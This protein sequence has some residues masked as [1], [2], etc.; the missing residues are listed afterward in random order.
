MR[1]RVISFSEKQGYGFITGENGLDYFVHF[2]KIMDESK[3]LD[4]N[5]IVEFEPIKTDKGSEAL[6]V[7]SILTFEMVKKKAEKKKMQL[8]ETLDP[9]KHGWVLV[10]KNNFIK[11]SENGMF[12]DEINKYLED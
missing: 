4:V 8:I 9:P 12:L 2:S 3:H 7:T 10:D 1:G 11:G 5:E 6:N